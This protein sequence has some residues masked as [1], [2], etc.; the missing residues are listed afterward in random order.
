VVDVEVDDP[1]RAAPLLERVAPAATLGWRSAR[2]DHRVYAWDERLGRL[3]DKAVVYLVGGAVELRMGAAGKQLA[4]VCPPTVG[5]NRRR[6]VWNGVWEVAPFPE[7]LLAEL[8]RAEGEKSVRR[9]RP[10]PALTPA[11]PYA[12]AALRREAELVRTAQPGTRNR[13]LNRA[14]FNLGQLVAGGFLERGAVEAELSLAAED[15]GLPEREIAGTVRS[16]LE[17]GMKNPRTRRTPA[18]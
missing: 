2:G 9:E 14:A 18:G 16:G 3:T 7:R 12:D 6:R 1:E 4:A 5:T 10:F 11:S 8:E 13:T 17:A 15:A